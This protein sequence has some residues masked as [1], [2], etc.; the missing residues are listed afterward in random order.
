MSAVMTAEN[1]ARFR[2]LRG[3]REQRVIAD[4]VG[5]TTQSV[6]LWETRGRVSRR[7]AAAY[8]EALG[9]DGEVLALLGFTPEAGRSTVDDLRARLAEVEQQVEVLAGLVAE[10]VEYLS[11]HDPTMIPSELSEPP[12]AP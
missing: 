12:A 4:A 3:D 11:P 8:D 2:E 7:H 1:A 6:S 10:I 9:A 5:V